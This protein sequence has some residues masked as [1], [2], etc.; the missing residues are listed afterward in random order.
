MIGFQSDSIHWSIRADGLHNYCDRFNSILL[1]L[2]YF[3]YWFFS[4]YRFRSQKK[5]TQLKKLVQK[6]FYVIFT[7]CERASRQIDIEDKARSFNNVIENPFEAL[8]RTFIMTIGEFATI[9]KEMSSCKSMFMSFIGK[10][11]FVLFEILVSILQF[12][13]LIAM[14][15]RTYEAIFETKKEWSRQQIKGSA[16]GSVQEQRRCSKWNEEC[17]APS[18]SFRNDDSSWIGHYM[19]HSEDHWSLS[20]AP[21]PDISRIT[22]WAQVILMLELSLSPKERLM[23]LLRYSRPTGVNKR[24]RSYVVSKKTDFRAG[25]TKDEE[26]RVRNEK[27]DLIREEKR[28]LIKKKHRVSLRF[29][30][31][32]FNSTS[33][34]RLLSMKIDQ[35]INQNRFLKIPL[36][37][38]IKGPQF[39]LGIPA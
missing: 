17:K 39:L 13:L 12:N 22:Q 16:M 31:L 35:K 30:N 15:T 37:G 7:T 20:N 4:I 21:L 25:L 1:D 36:K 24:I 32:S 3:S 14:M 27:A 38:K 29:S 6:T 18:P 8:L 10:V 5:I 33:T 23:H 11:I 34:I 9:Y 26:I 19:S 2:F 28:Q